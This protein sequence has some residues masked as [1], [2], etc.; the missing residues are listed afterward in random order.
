MTIA[1]CLASFYDVLCFRARSKRPPLPSRA[2]PKPVFQRR[3]DAARVPRPS[4][5]W[6][7]SSRSIACP[8][9]WGT[10]RS[11]CASLVLS[12][13]VTWWLLLAVLHVRMHTPGWNRC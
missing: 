9:W 7:T 8:W 3:L 4:R 2:D 6:N 1:S 11:W 12:D 5:R 13:P 10:H